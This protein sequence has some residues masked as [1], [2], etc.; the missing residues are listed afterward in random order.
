MRV[1]F[2]S[3]GFRFSMSR[4]PKRFTMYAYERHIASVGKG[5]LINSQLFTLGSLLLSIRSWYWSTRNRT[6]F[7]IFF[8]MLYSMLQSSKFQIRTGRFFNFL[9]GRH[10]LRSVLVKSFCPFSS[11]L[12]FGGKVD[13]DEGKSQ[14][15]NKPR[16]RRRAWIYI[17]CSPPGGGLEA[18]SSWTDGGA[19]YYTRKLYAF[20]PFPF[21]PRSRGNPEVDHLRHSKS[22]FCLLLLFFSLA[23]FCFC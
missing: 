19:L 21:L 16:L 6:T 11:V 13:V 15:R 20:I 7:V 18:P 14:A 4:G 22:D 12:A 17:T 8:V 3:K 23:A 10:P 1:F 2:N 9:P 5:E